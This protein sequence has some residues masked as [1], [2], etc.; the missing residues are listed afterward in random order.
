[1]Q[2]GNLSMLRAILIIYSNSFFYFFISRT[3]VTVRVRV[4]ISFLVDFI[5]IQNNREFRQTLNLGQY[6]LRVALTK[7]K[8]RQNNEQNQQ[9]NNEN[10]KTY[11]LDNGSFLLHDHYH[12]HGYG[13]FDMSIYSAVAIAQSIHN[14]ESMRL[15]RS[16]HALFHFCCVFIVRL[17]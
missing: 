2:I 15:F 13:F 5:R 8:K 7:F 10:S 9:T 16:T 11:Y 3:F 4:W 6:Y 12:V 17:K 1:M 14:R